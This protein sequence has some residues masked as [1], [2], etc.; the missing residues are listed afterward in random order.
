MSGG[1][2]LQ[3]GG[4]PRL[5][6]TSMGRPLLPLQPSPNPALVRVHHD[7]GALRR[8]HSLPDLSEL[9]FFDEAT[10]SNPFQQGMLPGGFMPPVDNGIMSNPFLPGL[11]LR[12]I[13][14]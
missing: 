4:G 1:G 12:Y 6:T 2:A 11:P 7:L 3:T 10:A 5:P 9:S 13:Y 14:I 8:N